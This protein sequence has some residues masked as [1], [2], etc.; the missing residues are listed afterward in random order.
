MANIAAA[1][2]Q[3]A[4]DK[5]MTMLVSEMVKLVDEDSP[6]VDEPNH[7]FAPG[8]Y[9]RELFVKKGT[10]AIGKIHKTEHLTIIS[11]GDIT[12]VTRDGTKRII[13]PCT[14]VSKPG[15]QRIAYAHEDTV[16]TT[17]HP[18]DETDLKKLEAE[19]VEDFDINKFKIE[20]GINKVRY[21][22]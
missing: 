10:L 6:A 18:T 13:A 2:N 15:E 4:F 20:Q 7:I 21:L 19:L 11:K 8:V 1:N 3:R 17:I 22:R 9:A 5:K 12:V 16:W 14:F